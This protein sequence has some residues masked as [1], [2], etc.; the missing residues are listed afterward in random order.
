[1]DLV[2]ISN[3]HFR[4]VY[5]FFPL[6][7][8]TQFWWAPHWPGCTVRTHR[9]ERSRAA[10]HLWPPP[11][12]RG[13]QCE[14]AGSSHHPPAPLPGPRTPPWTGHSRSAPS[15]ARKAKPGGRRRI[16]KKEILVCFGGSLTEHSRNSCWC[17]T[18]FPNIKSFNQQEEKLNEEWQRDY[19]LLF[20]S[21][22]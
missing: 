13:R 8:T 18:Q 16:R 4:F 17:A 1:M 6:L 9:R 3:S 14:R 15:P 10:G 20:H 11:L 7:S 5:L 2:S 21:Y 22:Q 19:F 12:G